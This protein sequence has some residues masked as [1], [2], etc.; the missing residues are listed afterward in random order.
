ME[1]ILQRRAVNLHHIT[2]IALFLTNYHIRIQTTRHCIDYDLL[3]LS[4]YYRDGTTDST[5][6]WLKPVLPPKIE[7]CKEVI[8]VG[9]LV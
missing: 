6:F 2:N 8:D 3:Q 4:I 1:E 9:L 7:Y 5:T